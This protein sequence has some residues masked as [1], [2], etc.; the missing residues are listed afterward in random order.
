M[1][2][3]APAGNWDSLVAALANGA[4]AVYLG[5]Q[6][7]S[8]RQSAANFSDEDLSRAVELARLRDKQI[9]LTINTL[10][11]E[12][13][14][15]SV[16]DYAWSVYRL[17]VN[18]IIV[19][20]LG[21][22]NALRQAIPDLRIHASTQM[23][24]HNSEGARLLMDMGVARIVLARELTLQDIARIKHDV[25][26]MEFEVFTHGALCFSYSGQCL[27]SSMVGGRSG[28]RGRCAQ[29]CRLPY[30]LLKGPQTALEVVPTPGKHLLS[31][32]DL[33][34]LDYLPDLAAAGV[35]S[36]KIEGRMKR[37]EYVAVV[38][39]VYRQALD[40]LQARS[41]YHPAPEWKTQLMQIFNRSLTPGHT[42]PGSHNVLSM[43]RPNNRGV[44]I[45][46]VAAQQGDRT[47]I[48]LSESLSLGDGVE[49]WV[50]QGKGPA[51]I[52][53]EILYN[54]ER[55]SQGHRGQVVTIPLKGRA[56]PDDRVFKTHDQALAV[57][58]DESMKRAAQYKYPID[59]KVVIAEGRPLEIILGDDRGHQ[60]AV[61]GSHPAV[62]A[63]DR[64]LEEAVIIE[65]I[66]RIG[67]T[68]FEIRSVHIDYPGSLIIPFSDLNDT[69]RRALDALLTVCLG[70]PQ[71]G[72][73]AEERFHQVKHGYR[74]VHR[75]KKSSMPLLT[76][77]VGGC[78]EA[79]KAIMA[80]AD[81]V[82]LAL[83]GIGSK[84]PGMEQMADL[85]GWARQRGA[86]LVPVLPRIQKPGELDVW[87]PLTTID[88]PSVMAGNLGA[89]QWCVDHHLPCRADYSLNLFN[90]ASIGWL[91][92]KGLLGGC[93]SPELNLNQ[94]KSFQHVE[95]SEI[96]VHGDLILMVSQCCVIR[97]GTQAT[98][99]KCAGLCR[100]HD[101][102]LRDE[103]GYIFPIATDQ[104]CRCYVFNSRRLCLLDAL[105][106]VLE[107]GCEALRIEARRGTAA[108]TAETVAMYHRALQELQ[109]GKR[110]DLDLMRR[111]LEQKQ[112][113]RTTRG[114]FFRGVL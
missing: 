86:E 54:G 4:D 47:T 36:L 105:D 45:G 28:N 15:G 113:F 49:V 110:V 29:P 48:K 106:Q 84:P 24:I 93:L 2:L 103:K 58:T 107:I 7:F 80:G 13:E 53:K 62:H 25:P 112:G 74:A 37:P 11:D 89:V 5:G 61:L 76:A 40:L 66:S 38:T 87:Q 114:H 111:V 17:G 10:I 46:R 44:Y 104:H 31:P 73:E 55:V 20:D 19:Q 39:A 51:A 63:K 1:E 77:V 56:A 21:L 14:F 33:C 43:S 82:Y 81:R 95:K 96:L 26:E 34:L 52:V 65:K 78:D 68:P 75:K 16:L 100:K 70:L 57:H 91:L 50:G 30:Q 90:P 109:R 9:Y 60:V 64:P 18:A 67:N 12:S 92:D 108:E 102:A 71:P 23:T 8:A 72:A 99:G 83:D 79:Q 69:R 3:L 98:E 85:I 27:F 42:I 97:E 59:I 94:L 32:S 41:D 88:L 6:Q 101:Y 35:H 22:L